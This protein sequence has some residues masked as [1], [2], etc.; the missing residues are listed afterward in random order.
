[1][2]EA[3]RPLQPRPAY[4]PLVES[5]RIEGTRVHDRDGKHVGTI[6]HLIIEKVR[7]RVVYVVAS[8][9]GLMGFGERLHTI[10]WEKLAYDTLFQAYRLEVTEAELQDAPPLPHDWDREQENAFRDYWGVGR[11]GW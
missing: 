3:Q 8:F 5:H 1:M 7:G 10:P 9:G 11:Y 2:T 6:D 4:H